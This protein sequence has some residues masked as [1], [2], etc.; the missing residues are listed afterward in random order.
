[1]TVLQPEHLLEKDK[2][3]SSE[4]ARLRMVL[5]VGVAGDCSSTA[6]RHFFQPLAVRQNR[7][8][9][10]RATVGSRTGGTIALHVVSVGFHQ[11]GILWS[12]QLNP[13]VGPGRRDYL[14]V[15]GGCSPAVGTGEGVCSDGRG[16]VLGCLMLPYSDAMQN[17]TGGSSCGRQSLKRPVVCA[18]Q[19]SGE[20]GGLTKGPSPSTLLF[21]H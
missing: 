15:M 6:P 3:L 12:L 9:A 2:P 1:M 17:P 4:P 7:G 8:R 10:C 16:A 20:S 11:G 5:S 21:R 13:V 18:L 19:L 14:P